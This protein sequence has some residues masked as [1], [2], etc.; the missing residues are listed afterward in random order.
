[1]TSSA[2]GT[3]CLS[4]PSDMPAGDLAPA[5]MALASG[6]HPLQ[7]AS[8]SPL[9]SWS[10]RGVL[11]TPADV[12]R[13]APPS[14]GCPEHPRPRELR[15]HACPWPQPVR[16]PHRTTLFAWR[17][18][19]RPLACPG[20]HREGAIGVLISNPQEQDRS[21]VSLLQP[22]NSLSCLRLRCRSLF[23]PFQHCEVTHDKKK[24]VLPH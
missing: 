24:V 6:P 14:S 17:Q 11:A 4:S 21:S 8:P 22:Q 7:L 2:P 10:L 19:Y 9:F 15:T 23:R 3:S 16:F 1:M 18:G 12:M 13:T 20:K 5:P